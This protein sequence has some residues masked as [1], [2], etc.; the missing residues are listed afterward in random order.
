MHGEPE[1]LHLDEKLKAQ[2]TEY[3][4]EGKEMATGK[5]GIEI[6]N[7]GFLLF[8]IILFIIGLAA[9]FYQQTKTELQWNPDTHEWTN[10]SVPI[11]YPYQGIGAVLVIAGIVFIALGFLYPIRKA[12]PASQV[13]LPPQKA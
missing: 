2:P 6:R 3:N 10:V 13:Q 4:P 12:P 1:R 7:K 5:P 11:G 8:G 9:S